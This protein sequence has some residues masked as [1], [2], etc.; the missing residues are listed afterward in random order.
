[1]NKLEE[2]M[3]SK[4]KNCGRVEEK[5]RCLL[6]NNVFD[7]LSKHDYY[8]HSIHDVEAEKL[9]ELRRKISCFQDVLCDIIA[10]LK[11]DYEDAD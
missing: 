1:M 2:I 6:D 8:W 3:I 10:L 11:S 5:I 9:D 7:I 4:I